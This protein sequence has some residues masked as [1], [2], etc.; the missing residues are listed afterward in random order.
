MKLLNGLLL[1]L[2]RPRSGAVVIALAMLLASPAAFSPLVL[3]DQFFQIKMDPELDLPGVDP[4]EG[5]FV[6]CS[7][8]PGQR[9]A[10]MEE[11]LFPWWTADGHVSAFWRPL[12]AAT[13]H[14]DQ[15]LWP[16]DALL[17][18]VHSLLWFL[19]LLVLLHHLY[20]RFHPTGVAAL[21]LAL[22]A[23]DDSRGWVL[24][25]AANRNALIAAV[26]GVLV[27]IA[28][29]RWRRD[30]WRPGAWLG[31]LLL[32]AGLLSAELAITTTGFLFA[33]AITMD[34][35]R[36]RDRLGRLIPYALVVALWQTLYRSLGHGLVGSG[37]YI[38][39]LTDPL[40][41][42]S[43]LMERA[44]RLALAQLTGPP[45]EWSSFKGA[46]LAGEL[47]Y[48][49]W[50]VIVG[51]GVL[52]WPLLKRRPVTLFWVV[53]ATLALIP[54]AAPP[55]MDRLLVFVGIGA[56]GALASLFADAAQRPSSIFRRGAVVLLALIHLV[57][58][59]L[60]LPL[61]GQGVQALDRLS[62]AVDESVPSDPSVRDR[63]LVVFQSPTP[64][65]LVSSL[66]V[67]RTVNGV[68]RPRNIWVLT[69]MG[70]IRVTRVD[71]HTL[72]VSPA[73]GFYA[74]IQ[75]QSTRAISLPF[76]VGDKV[77]LSTM[78][79]TIT[80]VTQAGRAAEADFRFSSPLEDPRWLWMRWSNWGLV[81]WTPPPVGVEMVLAVN[82]QPDDADSAE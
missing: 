4:D 24:H 37:T 2:K 51:F 33:Y 68:P 15:H 72:H 58:A 57:A 71:A 6:F 67:R 45:A 54:V 17:I 34:E 44:P 35:G 25:F 31:P 23:F 82:A 40:Q 79:V 14:L 32:G 26:F 1:V 50:M 60:L 47:T 65:F 7:G 66:A 22:Y 59:P 16:G 62:V 48:L 55:P 70:E 53:G 75:D 41:F 73:Q 78:T 5:L 42:A 30:G 9:T 69:T 21:A 43:Q 18:H 28:H 49:A 77:A 11:G 64:T 74:H 36:V 46:H 20:R 13:H 52:I 27:L 61:G 56:A 10:L 39:P 81:P 29:D 38:H 76:S 8:D 63:S 12:S 19:L 80:E 3:D